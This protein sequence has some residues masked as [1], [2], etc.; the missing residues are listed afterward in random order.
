[1][2]Y[3]NTKMFKALNII[4]IFIFLYACGQDNAPNKI[5]LSSLINAEF[6]YTQDLFD[7]ELNKNQSLIALEAFFSKNI[8]KYKDL[9]ELENLNI[10]ILFPEQNN[11]ITSFIISVIS[12]ENPI[13]L[14]KFIGMLK[15]DN[16][17][18]LAS[19]SFAIYQNK[20][21]NIK[22]EK[23]ADSN[24][25]VNTEILRCRYNNG[26]NFGTFQIAINSFIN[27]LRFIELPYSINYLEDNSTDNGFIWINNF[28]SEDYQDLLLNSWLK[29]EDSFE[30]KNEFSQNATCIESNKF[31]SFKLI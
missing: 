14:T 30:V 3:N 19:C 24:S 4:F 6:T 17:S 1:M 18:N 9:A 16:F 29:N 12:N 7:C 23:M 15:E 5:K 10:S 22:Q 27:N 20:G 13:A 11:N 26:Y 21:I 25:F 28:Y 8:K 2:K 31:K